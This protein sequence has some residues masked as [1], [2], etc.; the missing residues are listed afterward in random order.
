MPQRPV[1]KGHIRIALV[2]IPVEI[3][4]ATR[5]GSQTAFRQIHEP[6]GQPIHYEKVVNGIGP[7]DP[8]DIRRGFEIEKGRYVLLEDEEI[9]AVRLESRKTIELNLFVDIGDI[10]VLY[11]EKPHYV[12]PADELAQ[13]A[14][15][16]L[17]EALRASGRAGIG[18]VVMRGRESL[19]SLRCCGRGMVL[20]TLRY[21]DEVHAATAYFRDIPDSEADAGLLDLATELIERRAGRFDPQAYRDRYVDALQELVER[22]RRS[23]KRVVEPADEAEPAPA[24]D[25]TDLM[26]VLKQSLQPAKGSTRGK[27]PAPAP[28]RRTARRKRAA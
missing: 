25:I 28:A 9:A 19:A 17:R 15:I 4:S 16:V 2:S 5:S 8:E 27:R 13:E 20:E 14:Y 10:P 22:K 7:I 26:A 12:V 6:S 23:G 24:A 3:Y 1:W 21:A 11:A 18:Q